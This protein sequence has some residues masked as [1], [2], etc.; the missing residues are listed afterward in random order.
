[1]LVS[2]NVQEAGGT[3]GISCIGSTKVDIKS[4]RPAEMQKVSSNKTMSP[5]IFGIQE[6][7]PTIL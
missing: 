4:R 1:M 5:Q 7:Y 2:S 3:V 6:K